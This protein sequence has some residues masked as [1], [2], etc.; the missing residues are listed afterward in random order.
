M[1][2]PQTKPILMRKAELIPT[3]DSTETYK[4]NFRCLLLMADGLIQTGSTGL[5]AVKI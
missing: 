4:H 5:A 1:N 3:G 2:N